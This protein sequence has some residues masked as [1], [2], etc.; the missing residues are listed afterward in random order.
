[1]LGMRLL[2]T[3]T[4]ELHDFIGDSIPQYVI[5]SHTW[6]EGEVSFQDIING[7]PKHKSKPGY[8]KLLGAC[9]QAVRD[10]FEWIWIDTCCIDKSSSSELQEAINSM[11]LWYQ[12]AR[13]C[14]I[15]LSDVSDHH[16]PAW[17]KCRWFTRGWTLQELIAP[18]CAEFYTEHWNLIGTKYE[19]SEN[20]S[21]I[22]KIP[23]TVL[24]TGTFEGIPALDKLSWMAHRK[25]TRPE[26]ITYALLGL[27]DVNM[28]LLYGEGGA[29]AFRRLQ[30][31]ILKKSEDHTLFVWR[32]SIWDKDGGLLASVPSRY[33][34]DIGCSPCA[35]KNLGDRTVVEYDAGFLSGEG[36]FQSKSIYEYYNAFGEAKSPPQVAPASLTSVGMSITLWLIDI[37]KLPKHYLK[38][39]EHRKAVEGRRWLVGLNVFSGDHKKI[40]CIMLFQRSHSEPM[41]RHPA[42]RVFGWVDIADISSAI[43][44]PIR[45]AQPQL[46]LNNRI[47]PRVQNVAV[48]I[49]F[50]TSLFE[51]REI[52]KPGTGQIRIEDGRLIVIGSRK[53]L[54]IAMLLQPRDGSHELPNIPLHL[55]FNRD[56]SG[57]CLSLTKPGWDKEEHTQLSDAYTALQGKVFKDRLRINLG[58]DKTLFL[59]CKLLAGIKILGHVDGNLVRQRYRLRIYIEVDQRKL[60]IPLDNS[61]VRI[62]STMV[63]M[64]ERSSV[65]SSAS[66]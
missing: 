16:A 3:T 62:S 49:E 33:C 7:D 63:V 59:E 42:L 37:D 5:L 10:A 57:C 36:Q 34:V 27:F 32:P 9:N 11:Y 61:V 13:I 30:E 31:E 35:N 38:P 29:K 19:M 66:F 39:M 23:P 56:R 41:F 14:Y 20:I 54:V 45:V 44:M 25:T 43:L 4:L 18:G 6:G 55:A 40:M 12:S 53:E 58:L 2:H 28:P 60:G 50:Q 46:T 1:M 52:W 48:A 51:L 24:E 22:T 47:G 21:K 15:Y 65:R 17:E 26:D 8:A 64:T